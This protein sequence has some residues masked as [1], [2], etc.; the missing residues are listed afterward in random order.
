MAKAII[1]S[2]PTASG[3]TE[4]AFEIA[5]NIPAAIISADSRHLFKSLDIISGKDLPADAVYDSNGYYLYSGK[6]LYLF[7]VVNPTEEFSINEYIHAVSEVLA[8]QDA[9]TIPVFVGG[10]NFYISALIDPIETLN[11]PQNS[12]LRA[13]LSSLSVAQ[14]QAELSQS[15][16]VRLVA[17]SMSDRWNSRRLT[18]AIEVSEWKKTNEL[19]SAV[20][21]L[22][23]Y[24]TFHIGLVAP[25]DF[26]RRKIDARVDSRLA[27]GAVEEATGL[28]AKMESLSS[29]VKVANG[30]KELF[31][32]LAGEST[33]EEAIQKWKFAE[34]HNA[35]KQLTWIHSD[36]RIKKYSIS[37]DHFPENILGDVLEFIG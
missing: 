35:K 4:L 11:I 33:L 28:F 10:S 21:A 34:Y 27:K 31:E 32:Y 13:R 5:Q 29:N 36:N 22:G 30:Y 16:S 6:K 18:R 1:I 26:L 15:D 25:L 20:A 9:D 23:E 7:D 17:M 2:G 24:E 19:P 8:Q 12:S 14:L 37:D 3:K